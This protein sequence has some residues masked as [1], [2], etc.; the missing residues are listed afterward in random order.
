MWRG[1]RKL[2]MKVNTML[3]SRATTTVFLRVG[4]ADPAIGDF[5]AATALAAARHLEFVVLVR[6]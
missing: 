4:S 3:T 6:I 2:K 1:I 5:L